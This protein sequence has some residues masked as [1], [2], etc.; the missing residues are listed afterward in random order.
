MRGKQ[1]KTEL[2]LTQAY[3]KEK[4]IIITQ[5]NVAPAGPGNKTRE[6]KIESELESIHTCMR[7]GRC[8][9]PPAENTRC[10]LYNTGDRWTCTGALYLSFTCTHTHTCTFS[11]TFLKIAVACAE[12]SL[13]SICD[14]LTA[15]S[16]GRSVAGGMGA[17]LGRGQR[18]GWVV[19]SGGGGGGGVW[20]E[21]CGEMGGGGG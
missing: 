20:D 3:H 2:P 6:G 15:E 17:R 9:P 8:A 16:R 13:L 12:V 11:L 18:V 4:I 1:P 5:R 7:R 21:V 10:A 19:G 14:A